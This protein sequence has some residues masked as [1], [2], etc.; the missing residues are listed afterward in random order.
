MLSKGTRLVPITIGRL[1][2]GEWVKAVEQTPGIARL[3]KVHATTISPDAFD[4]DITRICDVLDRLLSEASPAA[5]VDPDDPQKGQ[6]GGKSRS[7]DRILSAQVRPLSDDWFSVDLAVTSES[8]TPLEGDVEFHLH[9]TLL[10]PVVPVKVK[11]GRAA[12][13]LT[14]WGAFTVGVLADGG[15]TRLELDLAEDTSFPE[16]FRS[17]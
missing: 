15:R 5:A 11:D 1:S 14:A 3:A 4:Q 16:V 7:D 13:T 12:L 6:W 17:R 8:G 10:T 2:V 9:P